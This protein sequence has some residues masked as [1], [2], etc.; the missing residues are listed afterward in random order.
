MKRA[1]VSILKNDLSKYLRYV[2]AGEKVI[3][4]DR[5]FPIAEIAP[6]SKEAHGASKRLRALEAEGMILRGDLRQLK[7][8][9]LPKEKGNAG[10]L[11][12]LLEERKQGR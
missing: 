9:S 8:F 7:N 12:Q 11:A 2:R 3:V 10:V 6:L 5:D 1:S 4:L